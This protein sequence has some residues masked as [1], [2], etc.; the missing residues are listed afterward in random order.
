LVDNFESEGIRTTEGF[1]EMPFRRARIVALVVFTVGLSAANARAADA[2][3]RIPLEAIG[4]S[5]ESGVAILT[6]QGAKTVVELQMKGGSGDPQ[7]AHFH[8]GTC[9]KYT[10]RPLYPLR[11]V[12]KGTS[13]TTLEVPIEKLIAGDLV[14]NV[15]KSLDD[16]ATVNS[17][18]IAKPR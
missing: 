3:V 9:E 2:P 17:C 15:H 14:I 18:A 4:G 6:A 13:T 10:P 8:N 12:V 11:S 5:G 7:P 16:I 1:V